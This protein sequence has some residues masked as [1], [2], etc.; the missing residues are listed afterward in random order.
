[1]VSTW[2]S[3]RSCVW[4]RL[5]CVLYLL[6]CGTL[7]VSADFLCAAGGMGYVSYGMRWGTSLGGHL[8]ARPGRNVMSPCGSTLGCGSGDASGVDSGV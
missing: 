7:G 3:M 4:I 2:F 8:G 6:Y 5:A 1:M